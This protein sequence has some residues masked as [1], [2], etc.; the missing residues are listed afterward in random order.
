M[1]RST[2]LALVALGT[3]TLLGLGASPS[4]Y[5]APSSPF[6][7]VW[8][9][10]DDDG[11]HQTLTVRGSAPSRRAVTYYDDVATRACDGGAAT[12][13]GQGYLEGDALAFEGSLR[14]EA[15]G[16]PLRGVVVSFQHNE[17]DTLTD[18]LGITWTRA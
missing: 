18:D 15:A 14:C 10:I 13:V 11:S 12:I 9:S 17:D 7:G 3:A 2:R 1:A 16:R 8:V 6:D 5:A 4:A